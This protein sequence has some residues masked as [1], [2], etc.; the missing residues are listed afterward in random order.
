MSQRPTFPQLVLSPNLR[1][2]VETSAK[3]SIPLLVSQFGCSTTQTLLSAVRDLRVLARIN[4]GRLL[5][6]ATVIHSVVEDA[7][8]EATSADRAKW[9]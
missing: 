3:A 7:Y 4:P 1:S 6:T 9:Q 2:A 5:A 8:R